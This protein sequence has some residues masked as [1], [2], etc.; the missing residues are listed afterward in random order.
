MFL[1]NSFF[2]LMYI[3]TLKN[4]S[5]WNALVL[6][7]WR[8]ICFYDSMCGSLYV[9]VYISFSRIVIIW[10]F[11]NSFL[12]LMNI[13][14]L[15]KN[16]FEMH[17]SLNKKTKSNRFGPDLFYSECCGFV[18]PNSSAQNLSPAPSCTPHACIC[19]G[20][21]AKVAS[22]SMTARSSYP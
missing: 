12:F 10:M 2:C 9:G 8:I 22:S 6:V 4:K 20:F 16:I 18:S 13:D 21:G 3:D 7:F 19:F 5:V 14:T 1:F 15:K 17:W 11:L